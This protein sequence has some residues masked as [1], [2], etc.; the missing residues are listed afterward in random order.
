M[1]MLYVDDERCLPSQEWDLARNYRE[2]MYM[3][4][5]TK[6]DEVSLDHDIA[7]YDTEGNEKTGYD[8]LCYLERRRIY[9]N[10]PI[11]YI[12]IHTANAAVFNKMHKIAKGLNELGDP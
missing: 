4:K 11:P 12:Y 5:H 9:Y 7:S 10:N 1:K 2:A 6:Y 3:L 8:I